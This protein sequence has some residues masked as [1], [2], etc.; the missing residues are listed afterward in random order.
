M[1]RMNL[2]IVICKSWFMPLYDVI[3]EL[4]WFIQAPSFKENIT[5]NMKPIYLTVPLCISLCQTFRGVETLWQGRLPYISVHV[6][7]LLKL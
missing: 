6:I 7:E 4:L 3:I 1:G 2:T 5:E